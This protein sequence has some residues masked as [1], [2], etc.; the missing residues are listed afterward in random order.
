MP[1]LPNIEGEAVLR[2]RDVFLSSAL[3][4]ALAAPP[5]AADEPQAAES[6]TETAAQQLADSR[7]VQL[8][9]VQ[10]RGQKSPVDR[11]IP[12]T[13]ESLS[14]ADLKLQNITSSEDS[15]KYL[16]N[17]ATRKRYIGDRN[18]GLETRGTN[19]RQTARALVLVDGVL[20]SNF[21]GSQDQIA[22]RWS[23]VLPEEIERVDVIYGPYSALY[24][25]NA[26]GA[27]V[28]FTTRL[29]TEF[30]TSAGV[31]VYNQ[32][33]SF[34]Q[35][36]RNFTGYT[37]NAFIGNRSGKFSYQL[38]LNR[39]DATTQPTGFASLAQ[40]TTVAAPG[41]TV[42][43]SGSFAT[44]NRQGQDVQ[45]I[46]VGGGGIE[47]TRQNQFKLKLGYDFTPTLQGRLL[48][49]GWNND[50]YAGDAGDTS[51]LLDTAGN[52]VFA[53]PVN[54][55]GFRYT[56]PAGTFSPRSGYEEHWNYAATLATANPTG[57]NVSA[58]ASY[59]DFA[60]NIARTAST[61]PPSSF[62]GGAGTINDQAGSGW[63]TFDL[64]TDRKPVAG[65]AHWFTF[66]YHFDQYQF[67][68]DNFTTSDW[69]DGAPGAVVSIVRGKTQTH[70]LYAQD[71]WTFAP[72]WK[73]VIGARAEHWRSFDADRRDAA[74]ATISLPS[75]S[76]QSISPK[77]SI[78]YTPTPDW[79]LRL[80]YARAY[81]YPTVVELFQASTSPVVLANSDPNLK[82]ERGHFAELAAERTWLKARVR[83]SL[84]LEDTQDT[85]FNQTNSGTVP[86]TSDAQNIDHV[87]IY[88][89]ELTG[90]IRDLL[91]PRLN[92][93]VTAA[94]NESEV[95]AN[96]NRPST[97]GKQF[98]QIPR[99]RG[100]FLATYGIT[101]DIGLTFAGRYSGRQFATLDNS[102]INPRAF[103]GLSKF[104][105]LDSKLTWQINEHAGVGLGVDNLLNERYFINHP[106]PGRT[107]FGEL[108]V[109][110]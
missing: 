110:F 94:Y 67:V 73:T 53:G 65:E 86:S 3:S 61:A 35:T 42:I 38:G 50:R 45:L 90:E 24:S 87:R 64:K 2:H 84:Y 14:R 1:A 96:R 83:G 48:I 16:P 74:D 9:S 91:V 105:V 21:I 102:D 4:L 25:G 22:P 41:D 99:A 69:R 6:A 93:N 39:L 59:Y 103:N 82:P 106:F 49:A 8:E 85:L 20:L 18:G 71:A 60:D 88:G 80:S 56:I 95:L 47:R 100:S 26:I 66:G 92:L 101:R 23:M 31:Q 89:I 57:W 58:I 75:R 34:F 97:V 40:S 36:D 27:A 68:Q 108:R 51:Y 12:S 55:G 78:E 29:P 79:L 54:I 11:N 70:A 46:G 10:V 32:D 43:A 17:I 33:F 19:N 37:A 104:V 7:A 13:V 30:Q 77:A 109:N 5:V 28:L 44:Q 107:L 72:D 62:V 98:A 15:L 81:R 52:A 76:E 63:A